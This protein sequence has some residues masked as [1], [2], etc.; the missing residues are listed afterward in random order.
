MDK[1][2]GDN[3]MPSASDIELIA[4]SEDNS[5]KRGRSPATLPMSMQNP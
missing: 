3:N 2:Y 5:N 1:R 4:E